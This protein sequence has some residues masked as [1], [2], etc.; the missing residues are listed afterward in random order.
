[1]I[2]N[3]RQSDDTSTRSPNWRIIATVNSTYGR[4][5]SSPSTSTTVGPLANGASMTSPEIHCDSVPGIVT[6]PPVGRR[7]ATWIGGHSQGEFHVLG[8]GEPENPTGTGGKRPENERTMRVVLGI[9]YHDLAG[10]R[11]VPA[12]DRQVHAPYSFA[13]RRCWF[14]DLRCWTSFRG[15]AADR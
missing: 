9:G 3:R 6:C 13:L 4:S 7:A 1:G 12:R 14:P 15:I 2:S 8:I 5:L 11:F 10:Q